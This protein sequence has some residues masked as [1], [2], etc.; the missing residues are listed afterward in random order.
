M[1]D[2]TSVDLSVSG[3]PY[4]QEIIDAVTKVLKSGNFILGNEVE[5]FEKKFAGY[6]GSRFAIGLNSGTDALIL[7]LKA[8]DIQEGD[9][10]ITVP[11]SFVASVAAIAL[12][13]AKPVLVD[14]DEHQNMDVALLE[15]AITPATKAIIPVHLHGKPAGMDRIMSVADAHGIPVVEDCSQAIGAAKGPKKTGTFGKAGCYSLHPLKNLGACGD[16]GIIITD[17][18][19]LYNKIKLLRNHGLVNRNECAVWGFNSRLDALQAAILNIKLKHLEDHNKRRADI[20]MQY[21]SAFRDLPVKLPLEE[22]GERHAWYNYV[23]QTTQRDQLLASLESKGV[24]AL[25]HYP[26]P[27]HLQ[28]AAAALG[29]KQN[30]FP[31]CEK[32]AIQILSLPVHPYLDDQQVAFIIKAVRAFFDS[33]PGDPA[34]MNNELLQTKTAV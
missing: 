20:A 2:I 12:I 23:I 17:D 28:P 7:A 9:E 8:L 16:A 19:T 33:T 15:Q 31:V 14:V 3:L 25:I 27:V 18:E 29:Y 11:N 34:G 26:V 21:Q 22:T 30:S 24:Q 6:H 4:Q 32:Q 13:G 5:A 10:V 1:F